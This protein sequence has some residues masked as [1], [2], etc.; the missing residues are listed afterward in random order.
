M[1]GMHCPQGWGSWSLLG[2]RDS[3]LLNTVPT[4]IGPHIWKVRSGH[5]CPNPSNI[6]YC[7]AHL[8]GPSFFLAAESSILV[9][10]DCSVV[11]AL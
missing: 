2:L 10:N 4:L 5:T 11:F 6:I 1:S 8:Y 7:T 9:V 3:R